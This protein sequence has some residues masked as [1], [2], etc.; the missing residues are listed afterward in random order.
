MIQRR[1]PSGASPGSPPA[2]PSTLRLPPAHGRGAL[3]SAPPGW[4]PRGSG[5]RAAALRGTAASRYPLVCVSAV[6]PWRGWGGYDG[7]HLAA[8][9]LSEACSAPVPSPPSPGAPQT[10]GLDP[11]LSFGSWPSPFT[12]APQQHHH[13]AFP[14]HLLGVP[15]LPS[16]APALPT[17]IV[18]TVPHNHCIYPIFLP[19]THSLFPGSVPWFPRVWPLPTTMG[20]LGK[21]TASGG[22]TQQHWHPFLCAPLILPL[23]TTL[24]RLIQHDSQQQPIYLTLARFSFS[25][26]RERS[27]LSLS[28]WTNATLATEMSKSVPKR[29]HKN[30]GSEAARTR[31]RA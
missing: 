19:L 30:E 6:Y 23:F 29:P 10:P 3:R 5:A 26:P 2:A 25:F 24:V 9:L 22:G 28:I 31:D 15:H 21:G 8:R 13:E 17:L 27:R 4:D 7:P 12:S 20:P 11:S 16:S 14:H 18:L 1:A